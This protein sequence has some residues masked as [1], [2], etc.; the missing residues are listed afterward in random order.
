MLNKSID[1]VSHI[2]E[3]K[4][5]HQRQEKSGRHANKLDEEFKDKQ[6][7]VHFDLIVSLYYHNLGMLR[8][9]PLSSFLQPKDFDLDH[10]FVF[11]KDYSFGPAYVLRS[12][13]SKWLKDNMNFK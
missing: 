5:S 12:E 6:L 3:I 4:D 8:V 10:P 9:N 7:R 2:K 13:T 11:F 1:F